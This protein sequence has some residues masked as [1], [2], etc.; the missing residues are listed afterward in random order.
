MRQLASTKV[1]DVMT[2]APLITAKEGITLEE[3]KVVLQ[4][5]KIEKL[6]IVDD[7]NRLKG[8]IT[9]KDILKKEEFPNANKDEFSEG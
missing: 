9:I 2:P 3:A 7:N 5:H 1:K 8:L 6:P 4:K